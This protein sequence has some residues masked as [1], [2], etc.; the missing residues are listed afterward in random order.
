V[1]AL[2]R[3]CAALGVALA[4]ASAPSSQ[5]RS[6]PFVFTDITAAAG[7]D[8]VHVNGASGRKYLVETMGSGAVFFDYD[9][10]GDP[11]LYLVN[12]GALPGFVAAKPV[13]GALYRNDGHGGFTDVTRESGLA[14]EGYGMGAAAGDYDNDGDEDLY[15]THY[16]RNRL[17]RNNVNGTFTDV[18]AEAGVGKSSWGTSAAW[19]DL[20]ADGDLDLFVTNYVNWSLDNDPKCW[21]RGV[22]TPVRAYCLP[23]NFRG[24]PDEIYRTR[25]DGTFEA[26]GKEAGVA[27][28]TGRGLG[29]VALDE[30]VDGL[31]DLY[32]ANDMVPNFLFRNLGGMR[33]AE[34][35]VELGVAYDG[36]G[37]ALAGMGVDAGDYDRDG[38]LDLYVVNFQDEPDSLYR[39]DDNG[40]FTEVSAR[41]GLAQPS[42]ETLSFGTAFADLD[43]DSFPDLVVANGQLESLTAGSSQAQRKQL[44]RNLGQ[45][46]FEEVRPLGKGFDRVGVGRGLAVADIDNDGDLDLLFT[47]CGDH[48]DLLRNDTPSGNALRLL[49]IGTRANRDAVGARVLVDL[50]DARPVFEVKAGS[51]YLSQ[52]ERIVHVGLGK[53]RRVEGVRI[54][55]PGAGEESLGPLAAG[56]LAVV[57]QGA[58]VIA[59]H[60]FR[61]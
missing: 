42:M 17:F 2:R 37:N 32:V 48:P 57:K 55:W 13:Q 46:R 40:F 27:L 59:S 43:N 1:S 6:E 11:D 16:G 54:R 3:I 20:D 26:V 9:G 36:N 34:V 12:G 31:P 52:N 29:V 45:G 58:G 30:N 10:D 44:F 41:A 28:Q 51:S 50:G 60:P 61:R 47:N 8:F 22:A 15:V 14:H 56:Q 21:Q 18:T 25:G 4:A 7:I 38:D 53:R 49:L 23:D 33:F 19:S 24:L 35:G 39:R 5:D